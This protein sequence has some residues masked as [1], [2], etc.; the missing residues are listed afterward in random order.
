MLSISLN[1]QIMTLYH[2]I[3]KVRFEDVF[4]DLLR[5]VPGVEKQRTKFL[6]AFDTLHSI[7]PAKKSDVV[8]EV[9]EMDYMGDGVHDIWIDA[10]DTRGST[11]WE[12]LLCGQIKQCPTI[13]RPDASCNITNEMIVADLLWVLVSFGFPK[14]SSALSGYLLNNRRF[15]ESTQTE[16]I[17]EIQSY[18][19]IHKVS[20]IILDEIRK[21]NKANN[22]TWIANITPYSLPLNKASYDMNCCLDDF[23]WFNNET[24]TIL[25]I[26]A[27]EGYENEVCKIEEFANN[28]LKNPTIAYGKPMLPG[29]NVM[30]IFITE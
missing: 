20:D 21:F 23:M 9:L 30:A 10:S 6:L 1:E 12:S 5:H 18:L 26:S 11:I 29:I 28:M 27:Y 3:H 8:I 17:E 7:T 22:I 4:S 24:N 13:N 15:P 16:R 19:E 25:I 2:L 14:M